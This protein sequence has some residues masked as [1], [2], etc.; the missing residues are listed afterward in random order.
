MKSAGLET[1]DEPK[2]DI[3]VAISRIVVVA[4]GRAAVDRIV[5]P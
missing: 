4:I 1:A 2:T 3:V 5:V